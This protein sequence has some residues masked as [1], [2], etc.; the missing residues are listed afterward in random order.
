MPTKKRIRPGERLPIKLTA[1]ERKLL[2]GLTFHQIVLE[3][4]VNAFSLGNPF[5]GL[6]ILLDSKW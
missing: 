2:E 1:A 4:K 3:A 6:S 5:Q